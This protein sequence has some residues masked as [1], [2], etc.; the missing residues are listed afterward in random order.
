VRASKAGRDRASEYTPQP[1]P[2]G[3]PDRPPQAITEPAPAASIKRLSLA[4]DPFDLDGFSALAADFGQTRFAY[5]VTPN[6][7]HLIR[8]SED[9]SF[10]ALY[11]Q[12]DYTLLDSRFLAHVLRLSQG[13]ALPVCTGSDLTERLFARV[14]DP[15]DG[16]VL[17][18]A[19]AAQARQLALRYGLRRLAHY[20]PPMGFIRDP[21]EVS[22]CL[23]FIEARS[24]FRFCFLAVGSPQQE[25]LAQALKTRGLACGLALC[26]GASIN[27]LT[28]QEQ[29][30]PCWLQR[31]GLEWSWR[32]LQAPRQLAHRYLVRGPR[33]FGLI[34]R[35]EIVLRRTAAVR[36]LAVDDTVQAPRR[37]LAS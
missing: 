30:A 15:D 19:S 8:L 34:R 21:V 36:Q 33:V 35:A 6:A 22:A 13:L 10:R 20:N 1:S 28:G 14:I 7:D 32:L 18:G 5:V 26:I 37:H 9:A 17:I 12:A 24:P 27:F 31:S 11:A 29:R 25:I 2:P 3:S 23:D 16:V 4:F